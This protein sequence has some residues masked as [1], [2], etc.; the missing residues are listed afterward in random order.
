MSG[1]NPRGRVL[2]V[3]DLQRVIAAVVRIEPERRAITHQGTDITY[4]TLHTE[5]ETLDAAMGGAL[6]SDALIPVVIS[7]LLPDLDDSDEAG[8]LAQ[9]LESLL[10]D[11]AE[12]NPDAESDAGGGSAAAQTLASL[13][14]EQVAR[15]P[16]AIALEFEG[17]RLTYAEFDARANQLA[18]HLLAAGVGPE[19]HVGLAIR[20]SLDLLIGMYAILKAGGAYVPLDPDHPAD[21]I[22]YV[23]DVARPAAVLTTARD[24]VPLPANVTV[25]ALDE[26]DVS[27]HSGE[28]VTDADRRMVLSADNVAYVIFTSGSTG[29]PKGVAVSH[30]SIVSNLLWRQRTFVLGADD[31]VLHKTPFTFDVSLWEL[32]WPLAAGARLVIATHDGHRD[33]VYLARTILEHGITMAQFVPS[34]LSLFLAEPSAAQTN[35]L[36]IV[37]SSGEALPPETAARFRAISDVPLHNLYGPTEA[38]VDVSHHEVTELDVASM[39]I[40]TAL[41]ECELLILDDGL[42]P[43][44]VGVPGELYLAGVQLARGYVERPELT[45]DRFVANP[46]GEPGTRM[47]RTGDLVR[48]RADAAVDYL[49]RIDFQ[50]K[51]RGLRIELGEIESALLS[52]S[53]IAQAVVVV[54]NDPTVGEHLVAYVVATAG[55]VPDHRELTADLK[56]KLPDY[57]VPS[58]FVALESFPVNASGKLDRKALPAPDFSSLAREYRAPSTPT[59]EKLTELFSALLG[60]E[61]IGVDDDFFELGGNSLIATRAIARFNGDFGVRIDVREFFD[62]PT[63]AELALVIEAAADAAAIAVPLVARERPERIPLSLAQSRMWFLNRFDTESTVNNIPMA[64]RLRGRLDLAAMQAAVTDVVARHEVLRTVYPDSAQGPSQVILTAEQATPDLTPVTVSAD[65]LLPRVIADISVGFDVTSVVPMRASL[66]RVD[67]DSADEAEFVLVLVVHHIAADGFSM[68]PLIRDVVTAYASRSVGDAPSWAPLPVQY[69][70]FSLW[71]REVLGS[72]DDPESVIARQLD[73]WRDELAGLPAQLDLPSDRPRPAVASHRGETHRFEIAPELLAQ[74]NS[75][76]RDNNTSLFMVVHAAAAVLLARLSGTSD[77]A[78]GT[79]VAGRGEAAIDDVIGMFVNTLVLRTQ[80]DAAE[81]F[82]DLLA[83]VRAS[84]LGA[85]GHADVPFERLVEV[86]NPAR[87]QGRHPLFQVAMFFQNLGQTAVELP[88]LSVSAVDFDPKIAK[89]DLQWTFLETAA[90]AGEA[91]GMTVLLAYATDMFDEATATVA[92]ADRFVRVLEAV[93]SAPG[94]PVGDIA[95]LGAGE[96]DRVLVEWND[97]ARALDA[98]ELLLD[99]FAAQVV[100]SPDATAVVFEG[101][102]LTYA[103]LSD[104]VNRLARF[105]ISEGV[106]P[107]SLVALAVRRSLD[108]VVGIYAVVAA[109]GA[110]VPVDPDHPMDRIGHILDTA[111]PVCVLTTERDGFTVPGDRS[112]LHI[113]TVDASGFS[114]A[115]VTDAER[116]AVLRPEHPAYVIFTS[117]STGKP[118]GVAVSHGAIVNQLAWVQAEYELAASDVYLQKTATT[119]DVSLWGYFLPLRV[120]ATLV[121]ATPDGHRDP[122]YVAETIQQQAVTVTDFVPSMLAVFSDLVSSGGAAGAPAEALVSLRHVFAI[123]EALPAETVRGFESVCAARL[124]NLYGPTEAAV[125]ITYAEVT[126]TTAGGSVPIGRPE[127]NSQVFVLDS[128]LRPVPVGVPGELYLGGVQLARGY[129]GRVDLTSDRFVASPFAAGQ[130][131]YRTGDLVTWTVDGEIDYIGRTDFQV[132]FRG[133]RI[134]LGEIETA[135]AAHPTVSQSVALVVGTPTGD[136]LVGYVVPSAGADVDVE[137]LRSALGQSLPTYMVPSALVVL[138]AFPLNASGKLDRKA[139]PAPVFEAKVFR[140]PTTPVEQV[141]ADVFGE[142]LGIGLVGLDDDFFELGGNSLIATQLMARL[143]AALDARVPVRELFEAS[144]VA[145][146]AA[147]LQSHAGAGGRIELSARPR[148]ETIPLSMAQQRMWFINQFDTTSAASNIPVAV[149][150][151][152][153]LDTEALRAAIGDLVA[154]HEVLR[155]VYPALDGTG[156]QVILPVASATVDLATATV[157][158]DELLERVIAVATQGFDVTERVPVRAALFAVAGT[159]EHVLVL[160][161]HHIAGDGFSIG[162][163][164]RDVMVAYAARSAGE[165]PNWAPL[166]V[167]YADYTLWQ[168]ELLGSEEDPASLISQQISYWS[169]TLDRMPVE[170]DLPSDRARPAVSSNIGDTAEFTI[171]AELHRGLI[172]L[173][174]SHNSTMFMVLHSALAVLLARLSGTE[175]IAVGTPVAG[176]G[177]AALDDLVGMFVN[178]LVLRTEVAPAR[179]FAETLAAIREVDLS[180]FANADV[181]FERLVEVLSPE[182]S[183]SRTPFFQVALALQNIG[184]TSVELPGLR[185]AGL[186]FDPKVARTDLQVNLSETFGD[187]GSPA[188]ISGG[189]NYA[190][191]LF[192]RTTVEGFA[193]RFVRVLASIVADAGTPVGDIEILS[194]AERADLVARIGAGTTVPRSLP[195]FFAEAARVDPSAVALSADGRSMT[196]RELDEGSS[197]LARVLIARGAGPESVVAMALPRSVDS[198]LTVWAVAKTGAAYVPIDPSYPA[199]RI[200]H[201]VTDSEVTIGITAGQFVDGLPSSVE[202]LALDDGDLVAQC[203]EASAAPITDADRTGPVRLEQPAWVIYTS[204]STGKPKGVVVTHV[205]LADFVE[206]QRRA[207]VVTKD[208]RVLHFAS[209]SF[210]ISINE[211]LLP[212]PV[213]A[214]LVIAPTTIYGGT[215]LA[216]LLRSERVTHAMMTPTA[217]ASVNPSDLPDLHMIGVGG[218]ACPPELVAKW[219]GDR[220]FLN[221]Y[222]PTETTIVVSFTDPMVPGQPI[223]IGR[224]VCGVRARVLDTR[225]NIVPDGVLGELYIGGSSLARGYRGRPDLT[226]DRFVADPFGEPGAR[227]YRTGDLVRWTDR[228]EL[229]YV[230]RSDF[231]VKV[232]GFRIELGEIDTALTAQPG[233][234]FAVTL[235]HSGAAG[236]STLVS[237]VLGEDGADVDVDALKA[238]LGESLPPHMVPSVIMVLDEIPRTPVGKLDRRALPAPVFQAKAYRAPTNPVEEAVATT[239]AAVLGIERVGLDDDFFELGGNSLIAT[240]VTARLGVSLD[241]TVPVRTLFDASTVEALAAAIE[242]YVGKGGRR[243]L[244]AQ[245]RP[246]RIPLSLAQQRMWFLNRFDPESIAYNIPI[247][248]RLSGELDVEALRQA[249]ADVLGRHEPLRTLYP[250]TDG[251]AFQVI[252]P[253]TQAAADFHPVVVTEDEIVGRVIELTSTPFDVTAEVPLRAGLFQVASA[254]VEPAERPEVAGVEP[255]ERPDY[256]LVLVV[257]HISA[258]GWSIAPLTRDV[259]TAYTARAA[260]AA[261]MWAPLDVQYADFSLWQRDILGSEE[262]SESLISRQVGYWR[263]ALAGLPDVLELPSDRPRPAVASNRGAQLS[264]SIDADVHEGLRR[265]AQQHNATLFMVVHA[266]LSVLMSRLSGATDI[267]IGAPIAGRGDAGLDDLVGMFVNTLVLRAEVRPEAGFADLLARVRDTDLGAFGNTDVPF[268]RLVDVLSPVRSQSHSPLFQ[269]SLTFQNLA[270]TELDL[271]GLHVSAVDLDT[272]LTWFDLD[273]TLVDQYDAEGGAAGILAQVT[274]ATDLFDESTVERFGRAFQRILSSVVESVDIPVGDIDLLSTQ[275]RTVVLDEWNSSVVAVPEATLAD[276]FDAQVAQRPDDVALVFEGTELTYAEFDA[277][278]NRLA[279]WLIGEG[280]GPESLVG[281]AAHRSLEMLVAMYAIVKAGGA[282]VPIDPY[283]PADRIAYVVESAAPTLIL[284]TAG[285]VLPSIPVVAIDDIDLG[286]FDAVPI[287]DS[288]RTTPLHTGHTAYVLYTSGS[289]G[290]PKGVAVSHRAIVNQLHWLEG[291]YE[292]T[293]ADRIMQR[294]PFTFDVSVWECFLPMHVGGR[295]IITRPGGHRELDYLAALMREHRISIA[296]FVPSVLAAMIADGGGDALTSLRHLHSG[297]EA[298]SAELVESIRAHFAGGLHNTYGPTEAAITTTGF[299]IAGPVGSIVPIGGPAW[300]TQ[301]YVLDSRLNVV[302][303]GVAGELYLAG[304]QLARG[305][306]GRVDLTADRFVANPFGDANRMYRTGDLVRWDGD[307]NLVY[308]GRTDFQVK[309]RGLRIELGE[310]ESALMR[311]TGVSQAVVLLVEDERAGEHLVGYATPESGASLDSAE[312]KSAVA[313]ELPAYMVPSQVLVLPEFPLNSAGKLDRKALPKPEFA[314][315]AREYRAPVTEA[316]LAVAAVFAELLGVERVGSGDDFFDLGGN[317]LIAMRL[318]ARINA[319]LGA[320]LGVREVFEGPT[321][322]ELAER[323]DQS[324]TGVRGPALVAGPRPDRIP[325]SL[326]QQRMWFLNRFDS[327]SAAYNIPLA[328]RLD[329]NL[330]VDALGLAVRDVL[331]RHESLRTVFPDDGDGPVQVI[332]PVDR[333]ELDLT[334]VEATADDIAE[335]VVAVLGAGFDVT[336]TVP[337]RGRLLRTGADQYVL[338]M[339]VHHI[340]ADG[341][342]T[343][344]LARDVML[345]YAA[346]TAGAAPTWAPLPV[347]YADFTLWQR[348]LLGS[349]DD[350]ES[351]AALQIRFWTQTL[352]GLPDV[353]ELP[354][355]RPRPAVASNAG[356]AVQFDIDADL[357]AAVESLARAHGVSTFMVIHAAFGVL[358]SRLS[359][360][361][362]IVVGTP[363]AGRS[364]AALD[365]LVGMFVNTLVLRTQVDPAVTFVDLLHRVRESNLAAFGHAD[366]PFERLVE[367]LN[368]VRSQAHSPLFQVSLTFEH[369][370]SS[371]FELPDLTVSG[372]EYDAHVAQ[373]D[374]ALALAE[375]VIG[376]DGREMMAATLRFKTDLFDHSTVESFADRFVRVLRAAVAEPNRLVGDLEWLDASERELV[377]SGWNATDRVV[378]D[379]TLVSLFDA[380]VVRSPGAVA[381]SFD[382]ESVTYAEFDARVNRLARHLISV[383]VG[384]EALVALAMRR[385]IDLMVGIYAVVKAGGAYVPVDPD[386]PADRIGNI[387][388]TASPVCVLS[389]SRDEFT[390]AGDSSVL[391][392]D[393]VDLAGVDGAPVSDADRLAPLVPS[394]TAYVIFTSGSTGRPKGVAVSHAAIV[395]RLVWMQAEY[396]L[397]SDDVVLQKTPVTFDVSVWELFWPLQVG[398]RLVIAAPDGHRDPAYLARVMAEES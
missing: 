221:G 364:E 298:L 9:V 264:L 58:L 334:P 178:T 36:R 211:M 328:I 185:V 219:G 38:A 207:C 341:V 318:V 49:G 125:S 69:A 121:V 347:Q 265:I 270:R 350:E 344:P 18:R 331:A 143:G 311:A 161:I 56:Q 283:H 40:G 10:A 136:Q 156:H 241:A 353:L 62:A 329:G 271:P 82:T 48:W 263:E 379:A 286:G 326:A 160:V 22:A 127:W 50:V 14:E 139:L 126:G 78:I 319:A 203:L 123:G 191:D 242:Q 369:R 345:A 173:A 386:Q 168:R 269:V 25:F 371:T 86:L 61:K 110:Y 324:R 277:R 306:H 373:F 8:G 383:G 59:E 55:T 351:L 15:T 360:T 243:A 216:D 130:R 322:A 366:V 2:F 137:V 320:R 151:T 80:V 53:E 228:G 268:E 129:Y 290:R 296:E 281:L 307:G 273:F 385:S 140:A 37:F 1:G 384:P 83:R 179:S 200:E 356:D 340:S 267:A 76:A 396:G 21:R 192:D 312:L 224:P 195:E 65:E 248:I 335:Q 3:E 377:V 381:L 52:R 391:Q 107:E 169:D 35:S 325:L 162:P 272:T 6:G 288:E 194:P 85:F 54:H 266:A 98:D 232:R 90:E 158:E 159:E 132:K 279:R 358:L 231:Q 238:A 234:E 339:A 209:P 12:A 259:M 141:V 190:T 124:H 213:G 303:V 113:D 120:G 70:D 99:A 227:M 189:F 395:N 79:P 184:Q 201:M 217:L 103:E 282:Y 104:R 359:G 92:F 330:D 146:L 280:V 292:V 74:L 332:L 337:V 253:V 389:T 327:E 233:I 310:I 372:F 131:M 285:V 239:F 250:E 300:N 71:Q 338:V 274:Y 112:V 138:E 5:L 116:V 244:V 176:R 84:D 317:S 226:A 276:L 247:A 60:L 212:A 304:D 101:E 343:G 42:R 165:V 301:A 362:D 94:R 257:H 398:G 105:L 262:D 57:M 108:L 205:G 174:R 34:M 142:V 41:A 208:S 66:Y 245:E 258:D 64:V 177:E 30:R 32:F 87:S 305:Y 26:L 215:E 352:A 149:R 91:A 77:I 261:P 7:G 220:E 202:W 164:T 17:E 297:G 96:L 27:G 68:G 355:D 314:A 260:G 188:G 118:K 166:A 31:R 237:Y 368:P 323:A 198:V 180:A 313:A 186:D 13:F 367:V 348:E 93:A 163:L 152:G 397:T 187:E 315:V 33:P 299:E 256:V 20:R 388:D 148:P 19:D 357:V 111:S 308:L 235:G 167:Q 354:T 394:N 289:T 363:I 88:E 135:L 392:I 393:A 210:D 97:S 28:A 4:Q 39:P 223:T 336:T 252:V 73:Y 183:Q 122:A 119:F 172:E 51:L 170:L 89:F 294:A 114:A 72:E 295:L 206:F 229:D 134:E 293:S 75:V 346:R 199:D 23:L 236:V 349:E 370:E 109:G 154:R 182:R 376:D 102:S 157:R 254:G 365:D 284:G 387:L 278:V 44:P 246:A 302:P 204:G 100:A 275:E 16:D 115:P 24:G 47:Y 342:S 374:L 361:S 128:R 155:T 225:L 29:K 197:R 150:L 153:A 375:G 249:M 378:G 46:Y 214:C 309:L 171:D 390:S 106:G 255:A 144:T 240:Q 63:V 175:D 193:A 147:R 230:G 291:E 11:A 95:L 67:T 218:E 251:A 145:G 181:P 222:G 43:V 196:Y 333:V 321:V 81:S 133:Q 117:G 45:A 380:Q 382:G 316:E 287:R